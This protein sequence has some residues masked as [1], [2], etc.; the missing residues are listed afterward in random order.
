MTNSSPSFIVT[1]GAGFI[2]CNLARELNRQGFSDIVIVDNLNHPKKEKNLEALRYSEYLDKKD[3]REKFIAG[4]QHPAT[5]VFHLG[6]CSSTTESSAEYLDD[7]N[8]RYT[9]QLCEWALANN[10]RFIYASSA[11][12]YGDGS[13]GYSDDISLI[14]KLKPLNLYGKSKQDFDVWALENGLLDKIVGL[15]YFNVYGPHENHK[16]NMRSLINKAYAQ[17]LETGRLKLF[18]SHRPDYEDGKQDRDF[19]YVKDAVAVTIFFHNHPDR[20]GI[21]N[22]GTGTARTWLDLANAVFAAMEREPAI[23]FVDMPESIRDKYQYH[24]RADIK[25]LR[26]EA[27]YRADFTSL[28]DGVRDYIRNYISL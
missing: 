10:S 28:E 11:A 19:L 4:K 25:K 1:G 2:G 24:T 3:F 22:C 26:E 7:N 5:T 13:L 8:L 23:D 6:A 16:G 18:K 20:S 17:I 12:T 21:F 15:K 9:Q 14:R 27:G